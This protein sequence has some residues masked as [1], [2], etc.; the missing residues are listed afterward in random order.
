MDASKLAN[1]PEMK[2]C[3]SCEA[4][5]VAVVNGRVTT[6]V[7]SARWFNLLG[8]KIG[9]AH[10]RACQSADKLHAAWT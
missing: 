6:T 5:N 2:L 3:K 8:Y 9:I 7:S 1:A 10:P 4:V